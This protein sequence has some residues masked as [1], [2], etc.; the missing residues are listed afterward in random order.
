MERRETA[1]AEKVSTM[2]KTDMVEKRSSPREQPRCVFGSR[3]LPVPDK[4]LTVPRRH[5]PHTSFLVDPRSRPA[6]PFR[7]SAPFVSSSCISSCVSPC[8]VLF[9]S[10]R[11]HP[12]SSHSIPS[13]LI[14][15]FLVR[16]RHPSHRAP[17]RLCPPVRACSFFRSVAACSYRFIARSLR[18][19]EKTV[20]AQK[21]RQAARFA[22]SR[23]AGA[24]HNGVK[25]I[26]DAKTLRVQ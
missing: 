18:F 12:T 15:A 7:A 6:V 26:S 8:L 24:K 5:D 14:S 2:E 9:G 4:A 17:F 11:S 10:I 13:R 20:T 22:F 3:N 21:P 19:F 23:N 25:A 1:A 16:H